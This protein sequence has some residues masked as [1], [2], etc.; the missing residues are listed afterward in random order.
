[1][2]TM[3]VRFVLAS[4]IFGFVACGNSEKKTEE[5]KS[6]ESGSAT[7]PATEPKKT[8][9]SVGPNGVEVKTKKGDEVKVDGSGGSV[10]NKD[11]KIKI[12]TKDTARKKN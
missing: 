11:V 1:M 6:A 8:E 10:G 4:S 7:T 3:I 12:N 9:V 2:K 5:T